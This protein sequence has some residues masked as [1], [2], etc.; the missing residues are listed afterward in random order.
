MNDD[1]VIGSIR[2]SFSVGLKPWNDDPTEYLLAAKGE[3]V[4]AL[5]APGTTEIAGQIEATI[6]KFSEAINDRMDL[7][8]IF[9]EASLGDVHSALFRKK[10]D[11]KRKLNIGLLPGEII[12]IETISLE[13]KYQPTHI[14]LQSVEAIIPA[15]S[16]MGLVV[17]RQATLDRGKDEWKTL[18][19]DPIPGT[20]FV[21][22]DDINVNPRR[23]PY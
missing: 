23:K 10:G 22:R 12:F 13:P 3:I 17:A 20:D 15:L 1:E 2:V 7:G 6:I 18:A 5:D 19:F 11:F 16:S 4:A 14:L 8:D 9:H 21:Y